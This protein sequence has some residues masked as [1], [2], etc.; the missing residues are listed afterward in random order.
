MLLC[1]TQRLTIRHLNEQ[2][3]E[4]VLQLLNDD[5]FIKNIGDKGVRETKDAIAYLVNGPLASYSEQGF[6]LNLVALKSD[7]TPI[8]LCG[9]LKRPELEFPD[10]GY[11]L[12]PEYCSQGFAR[13]ASLAVLK[14][15]YDNNYA[16]NVVAIT[17]LENTPSNVLLK[18]LGF[19][20]EQTIEFYGSTNNL[21]KVRLASIFEQ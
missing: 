15:A 9:L 7:N 12:L 10:L 21:Y 14:V 6:G 2:D 8:G 18:K 4:F 20:F 5:A 1:T 13:E 19:V 16:A 3:H 17:S 11:A